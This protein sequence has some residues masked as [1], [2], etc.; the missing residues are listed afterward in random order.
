[1]IIL[2]QNLPSRPVRVR[3]APSPTGSLH[4][5]GLRTA[6]YNWL[7]ARHHGGA[8][9]LR[10]EDTDQTR[11]D[12]NALRVLMESL[13]WAGVDWDEGP[14]VG[15]AYGPYVQSER[16]PLYQEWANWLVDHGYAYRAYETSEELAKIRQEQEARGDQRRGYNRA[17]RDLPPEQ[18]ATY[19]TEGRAYVVRLKMPLNGETVGEDAIQGRVS[20]DNAVL[21]DMVILKADGFPTY[22]LAHVVDDHFMDI[23]HVM[24]AVEWLPSLPIHLQLW[25]AFGWDVPVY[26]HLPVMLNPNGKGKISKRNPPRDAQGK[27]IPVLVHDFIDA[28][29]LPEAT[30]NFLANISWNFGE[31]Q[32]VYSLAEGIARFDL[33]GMNPVNSAFQPDKLDWFNGVYLRNLSVE[34]LARRLHTVLH[35]AGYQMN[36]DVLFRVTPLVQP[37]LKHLSADEFMAFAGFL[38]REP[39]EVVPK[40]ILLS[41]FKESEAA[42][43]TALLAVY[44]R[45]GGITPY[46]H[47]EIDAALRALAD[48]SGMKAKFLFGLLR[49]AITGQEVSTPLFESMAIVG[50]IECLR[51]VR[52][53]ADSLAG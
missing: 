36:A 31:E 2:T 52:A 49:G 21:Q 7:F 6:L 41:G 35:R 46:A 8:F 51:R 48:E 37:R 20:F 25:Q 17:H 23:S 14:E 45:L 33:T 28:G 9:I 10:I 32:E 40:N 42:A 3:F 27:T 53:A 19:E 47:E 22:H 34:D 50:Q 43:K 44:E 39:F 24:R 15:G 29:Y 5:G 16:L 38:F 18:R 13:H 12:P 4:I 26:A 11:Y 30:V 1:V